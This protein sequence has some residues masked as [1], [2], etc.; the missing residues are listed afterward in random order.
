MTTEPVITWAAIQS[1]IVTVL[2]LLVAFKVLDI[3][4]SQMS[5]IN[6]SLAAILPLLFAVVVR[7]NVTPT[8]NPQLPEGTTVATT[9][10]KGDVTGSTTV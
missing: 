3:D 1:A 8:S 2:N 6:A 4:D 10:A 5:A 7:R 9:D